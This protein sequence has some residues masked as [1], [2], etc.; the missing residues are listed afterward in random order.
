MYKH[1]FIVRHGSSPGSHN[2]IYDIDRTLNDQGII[3]S[4]VMSMRL[5]N[6]ENL[7]DK[8]LSSPAIRALHSAAIFAR[9]FKYLVNDITINDEI[10]LADKNI[11]LNIIKETDN[12]VQSLM[13]FGHNPT[14]TDLA[15]HFL[16]DKINNM[17]PSGIIGLKFELESWSN[18]DRMKVVSSFFDHP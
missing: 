3:D 14:F 4:L 2:G 13:I 1:L 18:I 6:K 5:S 9:T 11:M 12:K 8:I 17:P 15:N 7:P 16:K 10:Y